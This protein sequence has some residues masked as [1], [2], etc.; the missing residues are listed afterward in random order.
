MFKANLYML[1]LTYFL[2][3]SHALNISNVTSYI[4]VY[5]NRTDTKLTVFTRLSAAPDWT[6]PP[7]ERRIWD[8]IFLKSAAPEWAPH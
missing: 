6:P 4:Q 5:S 7:N 1:I 8:Q 3:G 2:P